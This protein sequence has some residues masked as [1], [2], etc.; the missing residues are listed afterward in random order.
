MHQLISNQTAIPKK[1]SKAPPLFASLST[2]PSRSHIASPN[3]TIATLQEP[4]GVEGFLKNSRSSVVLGPSLTDEDV[5][6]SSEE[7]SSNDKDEDVISTGHYTKG[8]QNH[9][10]R[11]QGLDIQIKTL[12]EHRAQQC[13]DEKNMFIEA[14][15]YDSIQS[16]DEEPPDHKLP[17]LL[18]HE[19]YRRRLD[20]ERAEQADISPVSDTAS[21]RGNKTIIDQAYYDPKQIPISQVDLLLMRQP[22]HLTDAP[23]IQRV[24]QSVTQAPTAN[25]AMHNF[26]RAADV[27]SVASRAAT[28]GSWRRNEASFSDQEVESGSYLRRTSKKLDAKHKEYAGDAK[29]SIFAQALYIISR[30][31]FNAYRFD[32]THSRIVGNVARIQKTEKLEDSSEQQ[33]EIKHE[34]SRNDS[35]SFET[36]TRYDLPNK[37]SHDSLPIVKKADVES[38]SELSS[39]KSPTIPPL[40]SPAVEKSTLRARGRSEHVPDRV[41]TASRQLHG[42]PPDASQSKIGPDQFPKFISP[43][44]YGRS[45]R[46]K[47]DRSEGNDTSSHCYGDPEINMNIGATTSTYESFVALV[48]RLN[49]DMEP[50][51][52]WLVS[53]IAHHQELR[54]KN[55]LSLRTNHYQAVR[56]GGCISGERCIKERGPARTLGMRAMQEELQSDRPHPQATSDSFDADTTPVRRDC[57]DKLLS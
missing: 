13:L 40:A 11:S 7:T 47:Q 51:H 23:A 16:I 38:E 45:M 46:E 42:E 44:Q 41:L 3:V 20:S 21:I 53:R 34:L 36:F 32:S 37:E 14:W 1:G 39:W 15:V 48:W 10:V 31:H 33:P 55:F 35:S 6:E 57:K 56:N 5:S 52:D 4:H 50:R 27:Y 30:E 19:W 18:N 54:Y 25:E 22:R 28:W 2:N 49:P 26:K 29:P 24:F 17:P 12:D 8:A 43:L 9:D